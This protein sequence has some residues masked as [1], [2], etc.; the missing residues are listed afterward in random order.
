MRQHPISTQ[1]KSDVPAS[2]VIPDYDEKTANELAWMGDFSRTD[3]ETYLKGSPSGTF[4]T[5]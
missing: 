1:I 3:A 4:L 5:R 2:T